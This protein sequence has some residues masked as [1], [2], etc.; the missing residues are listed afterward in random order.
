MQASDDAAEGGDAGLGLWRTA[1][2]LCKIG[3][4]HGL[5]CAHGDSVL[6]AASIA[7]ARC[8]S[9]I[10][11]SWPAELQERFGLDEA[12]IDP[13]VREVTR[14]YNMPTQHPADA[15]DDRVVGA[16]AQVKTQEPQRQARRC[17]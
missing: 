17:G 6:A 1:K 12:T 10:E 16:K 5:S 15:R 11:P 8:I 3:T 7:T 14:V 13:C 9:K 2:E 4:F